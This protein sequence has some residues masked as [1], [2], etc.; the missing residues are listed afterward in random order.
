M[1]PRM[2][3]FVAHACNELAQ[4]NADTRGLMTLEL[5]LVTQ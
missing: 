5:D 3:D 2:M 1:T 4:L